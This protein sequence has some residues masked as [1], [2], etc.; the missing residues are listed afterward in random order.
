VQ[1]EAK[2][3]VSTPLFTPI[4]WNGI[5]RRSTESSAAA[6]AMDV[7]VMHNERDAILGSGSTDARRMC[8]TL[9]RHF[10]PSPR[11]VIQT[12]PQIP[13]WPRFDALQTVF[14]RWCYDRNTRMSAILMEHCAH[15]GWTCL[16][17]P[18]S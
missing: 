13:R 3:A 17:A 12:I 6:H 8:D 7:R 15:C 14:R 1:A 11:P 10:W 2:A 4:Y 5:A 18:A 16:L 9:D